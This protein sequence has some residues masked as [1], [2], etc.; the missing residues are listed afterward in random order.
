[1][2]YKSVFCKIHTLKCF[3]P[4]IVIYV[5]ILLMWEAFL[6]VALF[7]LLSAVS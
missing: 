3:I 2:T 4:F 6:S 5:L 7:E 1:M